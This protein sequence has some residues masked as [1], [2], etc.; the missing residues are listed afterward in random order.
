MNGDAE[1][2]HGILI[3]YNVHTRARS[4]EFGP[5]PVFSPPRSVDWVN[6]KRTQKIYKYKNNYIHTHAYHHASDHFDESEREI[7]EILH[8]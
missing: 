1:S 2:V 5:K 4:I 3:L 8:L 7:L 6:A